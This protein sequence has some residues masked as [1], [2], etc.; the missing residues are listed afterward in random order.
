MR[1]DTPRVPPLSDDEY[2][3]ELQKLTGFPPGSRGIN[4]VKTLARAPASAALFLSYSR[5]FLS[6][7]S[8]LP[9]R[10]RELL[11]VRIAHRCQ[12]AYELGQHIEFAL[13]A[14]LTPDELSRIGRG[15]DAGWNEAD[16]ALIR[17]ADD[18][19]ADHFVSDAVWDTLA[20][21]FDRKQ[22]MDIV[23]TAA[24]YVQLATVLNTFGVQLE[25]D[26]DTDVRTAGSQ[27]T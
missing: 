11:I 2:T 9:A 14:G 7:D 24:Q 21:A 27:H 22:L 1:L 17:A 13:K 6:A 25:P 8:S 26:V 5:Y 4:L 23:M 3:P 12:S 10:E 20:A 18:I 16:A 15:A 19:V